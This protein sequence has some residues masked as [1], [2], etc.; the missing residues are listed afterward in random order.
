MILNEL[1][2]LVLYAEYVAGLKFGPP[3]IQSEPNST[4]FI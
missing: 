3:R 4:I 2:Y 1:F